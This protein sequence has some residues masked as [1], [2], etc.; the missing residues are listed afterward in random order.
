MI[1]RRKHGLKYGFSGQD[2]SFPSYHVAFSF[3]FSW[4]Q[5]G[6]FIKYKADLL[7]SNP[8]NFKQSLFGVVQSHSKSH[9]R[10]NS[11][12]SIKIQLI[13]EFNKYQ[14]NFRLEEMI[15]AIFF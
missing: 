3:Y 4:I 12:E 1:R 2:I 10:T 11:F 6:S 15:C 9:H 8:A 13:P 5:R 14:T 7:N